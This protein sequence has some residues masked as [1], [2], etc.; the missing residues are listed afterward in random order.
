MV[1]YHNSIAAIQRE[2][3]CELG[4][5]TCFFFQE[6]IARNY[7]YG[8][9]ENSDEIYITLMATDSSF[10]NKLQSIHTNGRVTTH[11]A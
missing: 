4:M 11:L 1:K 8:V 9:N 6:T 10:E 7:R 3:S 2:K 5:T